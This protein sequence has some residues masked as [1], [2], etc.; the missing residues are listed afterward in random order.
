MQVKTPELKFHDRP[1]VAKVCITLA[2]LGEDLGWIDL[3]Q[4]IAIKTN[5]SIE[6]LINSHCKYQPIYLQI[7]IQQ[8]KDDQYRCQLQHGKCSSV[9]NEEKFEEDQTIEK[10][11]D[12]EKEKTPIMTIMIQR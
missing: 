2:D 5:Y 7:Q 3:A 6:C 9:L 8:Y 4:L 1:S 11:T 12:V 10:N